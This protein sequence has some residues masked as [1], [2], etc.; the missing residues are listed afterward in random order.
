M[1]AIFCF[2]MASLY[3]FGQEDG[4]VVAGRVLEEYRVLVTEVTAAK[5]G[6]LSVSKEWLQLLEQRLNKSLREKTALER[7]QN[8]GE[9]GLEG[10]IGQID[11]RKLVKDV[12][13]VL[14]NYKVEDG[15][16]NLSRADVDS[17]L[18]KFFEEVGMFQ[19]VG[20]LGN[21]DLYRLVKLGGEIS[22]L[23]DVTRSDIFQDRVCDKVKSCEEWL[24]RTK[25]TLFDLGDW[26]EEFK[27]SKKI[28]IE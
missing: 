13:V 8:A 26:V 4:S 7:R 14:H 19:Q 18:K 12:I 23:R 2:L 9:G 17:N 22:I 16:K 27:K 20:S 3:A 15:I 21:H 5:E 25:T 24:D 28:I 11:H 1:R 6:N 10:I